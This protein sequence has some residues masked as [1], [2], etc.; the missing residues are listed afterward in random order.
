MGVNPNIPIIPAVIPPHYT[1]EIPVSYTE[2]DN[3]TY[4]RRTYIDVVE[5]VNIPLASS[6]DWW[7][8]NICGSDEKYS[9]PAID[10][11]VFKRQYRINQNGVNNYKAYLFDGN[12]DIIEDTTGISM[13]IFTDGFTNKYL[14]ITLNVSDIPSDCFYFRLYAF[15]EAFDEGDLATCIALKLS[16]GRG[17]KESEVLCMLE[18]QADPTIYYSEIF[19]K[20]NDTCEDTILLEAEYPYYDCNKNF[21]NASPQTGN[22]SF[23]SLKVRIPGTI[24]KSEMA[25]EETLIFNT[26]RNSKQ[27]DTYVLRT[28]K[29]PPYVVEQLAV[30]FQAKSFTI[31]GVSYKMAS[32]R[33]SK[34]FEEGRMWIINTTLMRDCDLD[35]LCS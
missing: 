31:D 16:L 8:C 20:T 4:I 29:L 19:R 35:F 23:N 30:I 33:L 5:C 17:Q 26:K 34:N 11:D 21:Y 12:D 14:N 25:F 6:P 24:E 27:T 28:E 22:N 32:K 2:E 7:N 3:N 9:Q 18:Q 1:C 15:A 10:G 13:E